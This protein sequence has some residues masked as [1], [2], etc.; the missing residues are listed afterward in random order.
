MR[1]EILV[2]FFFFTEAKSGDLFAWEK[3]WSHS[4]YQTLQI[5]ETATTKG[6]VKR[7]HLI[8]A[9]RNQESLS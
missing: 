9:R 1:V 4:Y 2:L 8:I 6:L 5:S 3:M 7:I